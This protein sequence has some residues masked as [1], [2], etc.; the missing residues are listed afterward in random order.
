MEIFWELVKEN[1]INEIKIII[2]WVK[3]IF[4]VYIGLGIVWWKF[5]Y[6]LFEN[7]IYGGWIDNIF[8]VK[9]F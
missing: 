3:V 4:V 9:V 8:D 6:G 1:I 2:S 7:V 5:V